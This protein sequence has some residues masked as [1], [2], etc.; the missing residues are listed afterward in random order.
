MS[1]LVQISFQVKTSEAEKN[2]KKLHSDT[3]NLN[4]ITLKATNSVVKLGSSYS[5]QNTYLNELNKSYLST[6]N[7]VFKLNQELVNVSKEINNSNI[8]LS[9]QKNK[10]DEVTLSHQKMGENLTLNKNKLNEFK[11]ESLSV[12]KSLAMPNIT[13][14]N[15]KSYELIKGFNHI[16]TASKGTSS[17]LINLKT[18]INILDGFIRQSESN[19]NILTAEYS[20]LSQ[21]TGVS[22]KNLESHRKKIAQATMNHNNMT[23]RLDYLNK[24]LG[25]TNKS[26]NTLSTSANKNG[27]SF[28]Q[29]GAKMLG[30]AGAAVGIREAIS[31]GKKSIE[32]N[33]NM[34]ETQNK[35]NVVYGEHSK[36]ANAWAENYSKVLGMSELKTKESMGDIQNLFTGFGMDRKTSMNLSKDIVMLANDLDSFNN[37]SSRGIDVHKTMQSALMGESEAAK[38]LGASILEP[39]MNTAAMALGF[40]KYSN[41][42][43][44]TTKIMIRMKAIQMQSKDAIGDSVRSQ[45]TEVAMRR[46]LNSEIEKFQNVLGEKLMPLQLKYLDTGTK[47]IEFLTNNFDG[48]MLVTEALGVMFAS[49][50]GYKIGIG[51]TK[52]YKGV[53]IAFGTAQTILTGIIK[54]QTLAQIKLNLAMNANPIGLIIGGITLLAGAGY[55]LYKNWDKLKNITLQL[56]EAFKGGPLEKILG[57]FSKFKDEGDIKKQIRIEANIDKNLDSIYKKDDLTKTLSLSENVD[58]SHRNGLTSVPFDGYVAELHKGER[59]L[60]AEESKAYNSTI[61][62]NTVNTSKINNVNQKPQNNKITIQIDKIIENISVKNSSELDY[63]SIASKV[64]EHIIP[65]LEIAL[66]EV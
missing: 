45:G 30:Y 44:E 16:G 54:G 17:D 25:H 8:N 5:L 55:Y 12:N 24:K 9:G 57:W 6:S 2:L 53:T 65:K 59:V 64:V 43:D 41:K 20:E 62:N 40:K 39:Q 13:L 3:N 37:L 42:M 52:A 29:L 23:K 51:L 18:N 38:T 7:E 19:L 11:Q 61:N 27:L 26:M 46:A 1:D 21:K 31:L 15:Q 35:F 33:S 63:K 28:K 49:Y 66:A 58:G 60:T 48:I 36:A 34:I 14:L 10:I 22:T 32:V 4:Q 56:W 50:T 47:T